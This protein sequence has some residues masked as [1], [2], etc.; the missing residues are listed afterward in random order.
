[1]ENICDT[2]YTPVIHVI[3]RIVRI[4]YNISMDAYFRTFG[5]EHCSNNDIFLCLIDHIIA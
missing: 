2:E 3:V 1:M 5:W 4:K